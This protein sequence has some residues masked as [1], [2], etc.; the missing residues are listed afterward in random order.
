[1]RFLAISA[2][3]LFAI[4]ILAE[5]VLAD[6]P[7]IGN[8]LVHTQAVEPGGSFSVT[9]YDLDPGTVV[10]LEV[11]QGD[12]SAPAGSARVL[13]DGTFATTAVVPT[14]FTNGYAELVGTGSEGGRWVASVLVG[15]PGEPATQG[16]TS[17][18]DE[19]AIALVVFLIGLVIFA[20]AGT[21]YLRGPRRRS[22]SPD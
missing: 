1:M 6:E 2:S 18:V 10:E 13:E 21:H 9:G 17:P 16:T 20:V 14:S 7:V 8:I 15:T 5:P 19:R 4:A 11:R 3:C 12:A 22:H